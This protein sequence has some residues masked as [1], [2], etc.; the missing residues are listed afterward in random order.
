MPARLDVKITIGASGAV[1]S[2]SGSFLKSVTKKATGLY[3]IRFQDT[4]YRLIGMQSVITSPTPGGTVNA[5]SFVTGTAYRITTVGNTD[6]TAIGL[7]SGLT[8][9]VGM[10]FIASGIGAGTGVAKAV[11]N[12]GIA[13]IELLDAGTELVPANAG[14][15]QQGAVL[16]IQTLGLSAAAPTLTM[17]SYTP[18]GT[19]DGATPPIFTGTPAVLTGTV[20]APALSYAPAHPGD[21]SVIYLSFLL[22]SS[23]VTV[24]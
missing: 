10:S 20:S 15:A 24:S 11:G 18:Q 22:D 4:Y 21:G 17:N 3:E 14:S 19:N 7:A 1:S 5:G 9:A 16:N 12:S 8:A 6:W 2:S 13:K 23:S